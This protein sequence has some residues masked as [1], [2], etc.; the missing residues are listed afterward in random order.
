LHVISSGNDIQR[1]SK[2]MLK[3]S[4]Q[5]IARN[6]GTEAIKP[7]HLCGP[8][9]LQRYL[10]GGLCFICINQGSKNN[11]RVGRVAFKSNVQAT[12]FYLSCIEIS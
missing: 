6:N 5:E 12:F 2:L 9:Q 1:K 4:E 8:D 7:C 10:T 3:F 11:F